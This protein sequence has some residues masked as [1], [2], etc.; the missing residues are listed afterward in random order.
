[1]AEARWGSGW[2]FLHALSTEKNS[3]W[4]QL[5]QFSCGTNGPE[6]SGL[7][8]ALWLTLDFR[9]KSGL[10]VK[11]WSLPRIHPN[12]IPESKEMERG[13]HYKGNFQ[14]RQPHFKVEFRNLT[15]SSYIFL[16]TISSC[17]LL[18][19]C[20]CISVESQETT[21]LNLSASSFLRG[22][23]KQ[24]KEKRLREREWEG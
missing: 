10:T 19:L 3:P 18:L 22:R 9:L 1:M 2:V 13:N 20:C 7:P 21:V 15:M 14:F 8:N 4:E 6:S 16:V 11:Y 12:C 23:K 17:I 5:Q 24:G